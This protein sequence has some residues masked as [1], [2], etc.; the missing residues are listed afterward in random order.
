MPVA[1][2]PMEQ[3][4]MDVV[5]PLPT[6]T[7]GNKYIL[8]FT[9]YFTRWPEAFAMPDQKSETIAPIFVEEIIF[10]YGVPKKLLTGRGTNF[11]SNLMEDLS[12]IMKITRS[13]T[14]AY[15][16]QTDRIVERFNKTLLNILS[17]Y[18]NSHQ[19]EWNVQIPSCL[20]AY[21]NTI[22]PS[23][24]ATPFYFMYL[25]ESNMPSDIK[26]MP[27]VTQYLDVPDYKETM[28]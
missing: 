15:H 16:P 28:M 9:D 6:T 14:S 20:F 22:H 25:R 3:I 11:L 24:G 21:R 5:G 27:Q 13:C 10:K 12:R 2:A 4:A 26:W 18:V 8:V 17:C 23:T 19:T 1:A 7:Q